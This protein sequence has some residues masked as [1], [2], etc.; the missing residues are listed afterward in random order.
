MFMVLVAVYAWL[1][2]VQGFRALLGEASPHLLKPVGNAGELAMQLILLA[3]TLADPLISLLLCIILTGSLSVEQLKGACFTL[4]YCS[5][6]HA[7]VLLPA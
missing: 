5:S 6:K 2:P 7:L 4:A 1:I 3:L